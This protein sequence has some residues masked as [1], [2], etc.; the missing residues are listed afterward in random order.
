MMR[1][2]A[3]DVGGG[4]LRLDFQ[5]QCD[6]APAPVFASPRCD[7]ITAPQSSVRRYLAFLIGLG[8]QAESHRALDLVDLLDLDVPAAEPWGRGSKLQRPYEDSSFDAGRSF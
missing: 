5:K 7:A 1:D 4:I 3:I 2:E 8:S 6:A